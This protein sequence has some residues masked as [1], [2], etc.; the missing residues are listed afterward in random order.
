MGALVYLPW[1]GARGLKGL[2][3]LKYYNVQKW[4]S[5]FSLWLN[6]AKNMHYMRKHFKNNSCSALNSVKKDNGRTC[7]SPSG[8]ELWGSKDCHL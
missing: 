5:G 3:P 6:A 7:L 2:P 8:M 4:E 1:S